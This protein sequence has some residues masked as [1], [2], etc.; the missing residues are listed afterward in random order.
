[1]NKSTIAQVHAAIASHCAKGG[2]LNTPEDI[3]QA[4]QAAGIQAPEMYEP[5]HETTPPAVGE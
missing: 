3:K 1:M 2:S 4:C 5:Q